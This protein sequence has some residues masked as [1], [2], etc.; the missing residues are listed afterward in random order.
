MKNLRKLSSVALALLAGAPSA[1]WAQV[2]ALPGGAALAVPPTAAV[3]VG[4]VGPVAPVAAVA[5][6]NNLWSFLFPTPIQRA[7]C[8]AHFCGSQLGQLINNSLAPASAMTGGVIPRLCP[9]PLLNPGI[10]PPDSAQGA[11]AAI[12]ADTAAAAQRRAAVRYLGTVDCNWWPDATAGLINA[13]RTDRNE[14]VRLEAALALNRGCCCNKDTIRA[15]TLTVSRS[16][17]DDNPAEDSPRVRGAAMVALEHCLSCYVSVTPAPPPPILLRQKEGPAGELPPLKGPP[18]SPP[19]TLIPGQVPVAAAGSQIKTMSYHERIKELSMDQVVQDARRV[20][21]KAKQA[22]TTTAQSS[23]GVHSLVDLLHQAASPSTPA[24]AIVV[25]RETP[26]Q[27]IQ[28]RNTVVEPPMLK[29]VPTRPTVAPAPSLSIPPRPLVA[30]MP[31]VPTPVVVPARPVVQQAAPYR[32]SPYSAAV[33]SVSERKPAVAPVMLPVVQRMQTP[34]NASLAAQ[35]AAAPPASSRS[36]L[37]PNQLTILLHSS[38]YPDVREWAVACL[39]SKSE[40]TPPVVQA[41]VRAAGTDTSADVRLACLR[42]LLKMR[43]AD[44]S[45]PATASRLQRDKDPR[46]RD[47]AK[48]LDQWI[49]SQSAAPTSPRR[50]AVN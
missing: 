37:S 31:A 5:P 6:R 29:P 34:T 4:V 24:P 44:A 17:D 14:C 42:G 19:Q 48:A 49:Q 39:V 43:A 18:M 46:V 16:R 35:P 1:A 33:P 27:A 12:A 8:R 21:L 26:P 15:L 11:A 32:A 30:P 22:E 10:V 50:V 28:M 23:A 20:V 13:L 7:N 36:N 3:P 2:P 47:A 40:S 38:T 25:Q 9:N 41:L 45:L